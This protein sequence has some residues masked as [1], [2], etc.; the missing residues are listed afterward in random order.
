M[1]VVHVSD[2]LSEQCRR[3]VVAIGNF[4]GVHRGHQWLMRMARRQAET[5]GVGCGALTFSPHPRQV[6]CRGL[7][8]F[9]LASDPQKLG[10]MRR[11]KLAFTALAR[12]DSV[13]AG[14]EAED[15]VEGILVNRLAVRGVVVGEDYRF[16]HRRSGDVDL[17]RRLGR[18]HGFDVTPCAAH[19]DESGGVYSSTNV[20]GALASGDTGEAA[21]LLGEAWEIE[22][23]AA[24][25][26]GRASLALGEYQHPRT[27]RY[28][29]RVEPVGGGAV[30]PQGYETDVLVTAQAR[31]AG[32]EAISGGQIHWDVQ[33]PLGRAVRVRFLPSAN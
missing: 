30:P 32:G 28:R 27:G 7:P 14:M 15:F 12:F 25:R 18:R 21:R 11:Q 33:G 24:V 29:A 10:K 22:G 8:P 17:L 5:L 6:M 9:R 19:C 4:D 16:G 23:L 3:S 1:Q 20:R 13:L 26:D 31:D 2:E